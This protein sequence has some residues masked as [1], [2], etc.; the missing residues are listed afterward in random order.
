LIE[1]PESKRRWNVPP[2]EELEQAALK[3]WLLDRMEASSNWQEQRLVSAA[4][5]RDALAQDSEWMEVAALFRGGAGDDLE[6]LVIELAVQEAVPF[7]PSQR[8]TETG[9]RK[10]VAWEETWRL[11]RLQDAGEKPEIPVPPR[12]VAK[13]FQKSD[14]WRLRGG[15][16][17]PKERF[18]LYPSLE[19]DSDRSPVLGWAGWSHLQQATALGAY[20]AQVKEEEGWAPE[21][22]IPILGG[23]LELGPWLRQWHND[24]DP[25]FGLRLGDHYVRFAE[26]S[27]QQLGFS[28]DE[29][30][31]WQPPTAATRRRK[32]R[33]S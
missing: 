20:Y 23:M 11:Q 3:S 12:Y 27:G 5:L 26:E 10:R 9:L 17:V 2:W 13:D 22:L 19:R 33:N 15:L 28:R 24:L 30:L 4:Q 16:D 29:I 6:S 25:E 8:Y 21:R 32:T 18:I 31:A 7:L 14:Y 1:Q